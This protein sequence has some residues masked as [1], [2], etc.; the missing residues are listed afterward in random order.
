MS[1]SHLYRRS[2]GG[3]VTIKNPQGRTE[4]LYARWYVRV[5]QVWTSVTSTPIEIAAKKPGDKSTPT[6]LTIP[7]T[8]MSGV[9]LDL[10][11]ATD[12]DLLFEE[13]K[14]FPLCMCTVEKAGVPCV[15]KK[16]TLP[17]FAQLYNGNYHYI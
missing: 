8:S 2:G 3:S 16:L 13:T 12:K 1:R 15:V 17:E 6:T 14:S 7:S 9:E 4:P 5:N 11:I 10:L